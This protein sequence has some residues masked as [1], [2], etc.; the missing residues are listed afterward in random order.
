VCV[1]VC[2]HVCV[3]FVFIFSL[4]PSL[5]P[6]FFLTLTLLL[7]SIKQT[8]TH[9]HT[10]TDTLAMYTQYRCHPTLSRLASDLFYGG[11]LC[12]GVCVRERVSVVGALPPLVWVDVQGGEMQVCVYLS[13]CVCLCVCA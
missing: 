11:R 12:D 6:R 7:I 1:H 3:C 10:Q 5:S 13:I 4:S 8:H 2:V 9:T